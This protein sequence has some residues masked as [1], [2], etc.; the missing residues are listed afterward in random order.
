MFDGRSDSDAGVYPPHF[1]QL[2]GESITTNVTIEG[3]RIQYYYQY[4]VMLG[5]WV[6][7]DKVPVPGG[8]DPVLVADE[9]QPCYQN[10]GNTIRGNTFH[11][12]GTAWADAG[13]NLFGGD[14]L[15]AIG[16]QASDDNLIED[17]AF[18]Q[19][20]D[21]DDNCPQPGERKWGPGCK[22]DRIHV[23]YLAFGSERNVIRDNYTDLVSG[24]PWKITSTEYY[25]SNNNSVINNTS[26]RS[27]RDG[28]VSVGADGTTISGNLAAFPYPDRVGSEMSWNGVNNDIPLELCYDGRP[29][30]SNS[31][32]ED[33]TTSNNTVYQFNP[34]QEFVRGVTGGDLDGDGI[35]EVIVALHFDTP[36]E[37]TP[38]QQELTLMLRSEGLSHFPTEVYYQSSY[39]D[40]GDVA[41]GD[42][43][44]DGSDEVATVFVRSNKR[45]RMY[46]GG[47]GGA[48]GQLV[49]PCANKTP[50]PELTACLDQTSGVW[51]IDAIAIGEAEGSAPNREELYSSINRSC[52][53]RIFKGGWDPVA[54]KVVFS[55]GSAI[56]SGASGNPVAQEMTVAD[57]A[58]GTDGE[59]VAA[60]QGSGWEVKVGD[61][62][63]ESTGADNIS[64]SWWSS[65]VDRIDGLTS[66]ERSGAY[67]D[68]VAAIGGSIHRSAYPSSL[69]G[70]T[71]YSSTAFTVPAVG[72]FVGAN[73][74][75]VITSFE[76]KYNAVDNQISV[77][78]GIGS[79]TNWDLLYQRSTTV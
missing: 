7:V 79:A 34:D 47:P 3:L 64:S 42:L 50:G 65:S 6:A 31:N 52:C 21:T 15:G 60:F 33:S 62:V 26:L 72:S 48:V 22:I 25:F 76:N 74:P 5:V 54:G 73:G 24:N 44:G 37:V 58:G 32:C 46:V 18:I 9:T 71:I 1:L 29:A 59:L 56:Y 40:I 38:G 30:T 55:L 23:A 78:D 19:I 51:T 11:R 13:T 63:T 10:H 75:G 67:D 20:R 61:G 27:G 2:C 8:D 36:D 14:G 41:A 69:D 77:G 45:D 57:V 70:A 16:L 49:Y 66:N 17:N 12:I 28:F 35:D 39:W 4:A 53:K 43:D 68:I